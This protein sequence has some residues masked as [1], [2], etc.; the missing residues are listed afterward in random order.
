MPEKVKNKKIVFSFLFVCLLLV[1]ILSGLLLQANASDTNDDGWLDGWQYRKTHTINATAGAD[2]D[3]TIVLKIYYA[4]GTDGEETVNGMQYGKMYC[5]YL[6][7]KD[8]GDVRFTGDDGVTLLS[9]WRDEFSVGNYATFWVKI[10]GNL[11]EAD[12]TIYVYYGNAGASSTSNGASTFLWF[13][14]AS[15]DNRAAYTQVDIG[16]GGSTSGS[17]AYSSTNHLYTAS[18]SANDNTAWIIPYSGT[19]YE[20]FGNV[21]TNLVSGNSQ[22][23]F[24]VRY[25]SEGSY[26]GRF[27]T[28]TGIT[29]DAIGIMWEKM[30]PS[31]SWGDVVYTYY[32]GDI[33]ANNVLYRM[34]YSV[35]NTTHSM[36]CHDAS[37][38]GTN[39]NFTSGN[40]GIV[41]N[42]GTTSTTIWNLLVVRKCV[43]VEPTH[44]I[45]GQIEALNDIAYN[46]G[47]TQ[48]WI[49]GNNTGYIAG[50]NAAL[51]AVNNFTASI[52]QNPVG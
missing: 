20:V 26:Q 45:W 51:D 24:L 8:F 46:A 16:L 2:V 17:L 9:Y 14:D 6:V 43:A 37:I 39:G 3:Y 44:N 28:I 48:G 19:D 40:A 29:D 41:A 35:V 36:Y 5:G 34:R 50:Y 22:S 25:S 18:R 52:R 15:F 47:Y 27:L 11:T 33:F 10:S 49:D 32:S 12:Q 42:Y 31:Y 38:T 21:G 13:D 7:Q 1:S 23:G 30:Q 4:N